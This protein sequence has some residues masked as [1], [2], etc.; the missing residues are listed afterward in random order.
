MQ[1]QIYSLIKN[2]TDLTDIGSK[3]PWHHKKKGHS[4]Q[5]ICQLTL[6]GEDGQQRR[7]GKVCNN[8]SALS[9]HKGY[10]H[11]GQRNCDLAV[12]GEDGQQ[13]A[14]GKVC[15]NAHALRNH[16]LRGHTGRQACDVTVTGNDDQQRSCGM[17]Y[18]NAKSLS[19]HQRKHRKRK[20][21]DVDKNDDFSP[22]KGIV[23]K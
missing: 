10:C 15:S 13:R 11:R 8:A 18:K 16:K 12:V 14:C 2:G 22:Q 4:G 17:I 20:P 7:C 6:A 21:D 1:D 9:Y 19:E 23:N 5:Q 3:Q